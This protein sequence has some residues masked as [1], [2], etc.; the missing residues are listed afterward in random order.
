MNKKLIA[1]AVSAAVIAPV[2][3]QAGDAEIYGNITNSIHI[4]S[5]DEGDSS[6]NID[7]L[8]SRLG[9]K[10]TG[11]LGNGLTV[12]GKYEVKM[13][14]GDA[15]DSF[16]DVRVATVGLSGGFGSV[17]IGSQW[18]SY[19][20]TFGTLVS[21]TYTVA[22]AAAPGIFRTADTIKYANSF[23]PV[24]ME[25][26]YRINEG[27]GSDA[28]DKGGY[29]IGFTLSP[30]DNLTIAVAHDSAENGGTAE[31]TIAD[32]NV[33]IAI[34]NL[35]D[36]AS[37]DVADLIT[38]IPASSAA[39]DADGDGIPNDQETT[40]NAATTAGIPGIT[41]ATTADDTEH[42]GISATYDFG[43][44]KVA[45]GLQKMEEGDDEVDSQV[46]LLS[47]GISEKTSWLLGVAEAEDQD[48]VETSSTTWGLYHSL[49]GGATLGYEA[50]STDKDDDTGGDTHHL[51][52]R[53]NF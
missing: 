35:L 36:V 45:L 41:P 5:P 52:M 8:S 7:T 40:Y 30:M 6:T 43:V 2:A 27:D 46:L 16:G 22:H 47:G 48:D 31:R 17:N 39:T 25:L 53:I 33:D 50:I 18:S 20:N 11:D 26:D 49:G 24:S 34:A 19:F 37:G 28:E 21:P 10:Y 14:T 29:G 51:F 15:G 13:N 44:V 42:T 38:A 9:V 32:V 23:G 12:N 3:A 1:A 4:D